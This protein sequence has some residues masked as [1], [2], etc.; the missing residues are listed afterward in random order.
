[1]TQTVV[2]IENLWKKF[3]IPHEKKTTIFENIA[4]TLQILEGR[5]MSYEEFWALKG[6]DFSIKYGESIGIIGAN[7][8]G[9][10]TLLKIIANI[11]RPDKGLVRVTGRIAPILI[12]G[13]G[14]HPDLT[15]K[16]NIMIYGSIMGLKNNIIKKRMENILN[17]S[18]LERFKDAKLK[19]LSSGMHMRLGFSTAIETDPDIFLIDEAL[20]VGDMKFQERCMAKFKEFQAE[21]KTIILVSHSINLIKEFCKKTVLLSEGKIESYGETNQIADLYEK[22]IYGPNQLMN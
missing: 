20:A 3:R 13:V 14:F 9:K 16:E 11:L 18:G 12:L 8:S 15:V 19:N 17:F 1:M 22:A 4:A 6:I 21:K 2:K 10:S 5:R 7:G